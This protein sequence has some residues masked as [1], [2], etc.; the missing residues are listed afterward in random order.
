MVHFYSLSI[1][2]LGTFLDLSYLSQFPHIVC[3]FDLRGADNSPSAY[4]CTALM[5]NSAPTPCTR[6]LEGSLR[7][8]CLSPFPQS[9]C[10]RHIHPCLL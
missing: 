5:H 8:C 1:F 3:F 9:Y 7:L 6:A 4:L 10:G 2:F